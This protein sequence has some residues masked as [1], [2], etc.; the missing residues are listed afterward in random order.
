MEV[1]INQDGYKAER[2]LLLGIEKKTVED[3]DAD[4]SSSFPFMRWSSVRT[5]DALPHAL[6]FLPC[7]WTQRAH[8][9]LFTLDSGQWNRT[10]STTM[11]CHYNDE[12]SVEPASI[13]DSTV[14]EIE[15]HHD[16][17]GHGT[18]Y[19]EHY[20]RVFSIRHDKFR[21]ELE[22]YEL[23]RIHPTAVDRP[24]DLDRVSKFT[25]VPIRGS[26]SRAIEETRSSVLNGRL[27]VERRDFRWSS[28]KQKYVP[29]IFASA[30]APTN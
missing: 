26:R 28:A 23:L 15:V 22:T 25:L 13:R 24:R 18:G 10:D 2:L 5:S 29:S 12:V 21:E 9:Y 8:L 27:K 17:G 30:E 16:C 11:D 4:R 14:D 6:L 1:W 3:I 20:F 19:L 7:T